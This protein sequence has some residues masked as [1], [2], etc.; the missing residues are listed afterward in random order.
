MTAM[1]DLRQRASRVPGEVRLER[2]LFHLLAGSS[3]SVL[4]LLLPGAWTV[5]L[6]ATL[7]G[8]ALTME[9]LRLLW[10]SLN[11]LVFRWLGVLFKEREWRRP[12]GAT[13]MVLGALVAS[14]VF[15][16][17]VAALSL[18][19]LS[20]GDPAAVV[21]GSR[22]RGARLWGKS[23]Q[24]TAAFVVAALALAAIVAGGTGLDFGWALVIG[25]VVA[26]AVEMMPGPVDDN[27]K[28]PLLSGAAM[29]LLL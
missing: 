29:T 25:A 21:V 6:L 24:G 22:A 17:E 8:V 10:P 2:R 3:I 11:A 9:A 27:L 18:L 5:G 14:L 4:V 23:F 12:T 28:I 15:R 7:C 19:F 20:V 1:T 13:Y 16:Q 26:A